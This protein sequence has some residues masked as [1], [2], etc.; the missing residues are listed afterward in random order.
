MG[1]DLRFILFWFKMVNLQKIN[2]FDLNISANSPIGYILE[3][4]LK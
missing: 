4:D 2:K 3:V 1:H